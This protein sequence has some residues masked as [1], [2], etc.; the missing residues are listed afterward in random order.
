MELQKGKR[1]PLIPSQRYIDVLKANL[2]KCKIPVESWEEMDANRPMWR[3]VTFFLFEKERIQHESYKRSVRRD[4]TVAPKEVK[5]SRTCE[6]WENMPCS[7]WFQ[8]SHEKSRGVCGR[9]AEK[10]RSHKLE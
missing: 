6:M 2:E 4:L 9:G 3:K 5:G 1:K 10:L 7:C 8:E